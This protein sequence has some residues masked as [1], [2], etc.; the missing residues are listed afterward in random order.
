MTLSAPKYI[1]VAPIQSSKIERE[2]LS[3]HRS[4]GPVLVYGQFFGMLPVD[5]VLAKD[6]TSL[7]FRWKSAKTI[8]SMM[9]LFFT[10]IESC[11]G[12]R[13][14]LRL[15]F[16][17]NFAEGLLFFFMAM[18]RAFII[19]HL[20]RSWKEIIGKW[21]KCEDAFLHPP[22]HVKGWS[23]SLKIRLIFCILAFLGFGEQLKILI[24]PKVLKL[25]SL[26]SRTRF[27][28]VY[29]NQRQ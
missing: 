7:E 15:G 20:A 6:E 27:L 26:C 9:F 13:R 5:G 17:L 24:L 19:F 28:L 4:I 16:N 18:V 23:L 25:F 14:L 29:S 22:Y 1:K 8:Y 10:S 11:L 3:F 12:I 21:R 2:N